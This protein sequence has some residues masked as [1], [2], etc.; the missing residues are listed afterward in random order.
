MILFHKDSQKCK[1]WN[2][3]KITECPFIILSEILE[4]RLWMHGVLYDVKD[5][6]LQGYNDRNAYPQT[7]VDFYAW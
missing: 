2:T 4:V 5:D 1:L 3:R 6:L 7:V